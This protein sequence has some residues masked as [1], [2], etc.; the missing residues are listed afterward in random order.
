MRRNIHQ[1]VKRH[2]PLIGFVVPTLIIGYG[3]VIPASCIAGINEHTI[4]FAATVIGACATYWLGQR[5][6]SQEAARDA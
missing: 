4:G 1:L 2:W 5:T 3:F 6:V